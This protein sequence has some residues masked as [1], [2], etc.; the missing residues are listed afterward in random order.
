MQRCAGAWPHT[1]RRYDGCMAMSEWWTYR[2]S[3]FLLFSART[4]HR[5]FELYNADVWPAH[6]LVIGL[7]LALCAAL[8]QERAWAPRA[9]CALLAVAWLWVAW[10][11]HWQRFASINWAASWFA[12]AFAIEGVL[13][14]GWAVF[15]ANAQ[16]AGRPGGRAR[17]VGLFLWLF[18]LAVQPVIG[19]L[20][21]RPWQQ[22]EVLGLAPDPTVLGTLGV[23]LLVR[24]GN[25]TGAA[26]P[27][28]LAIAWWLLCPIPLL[29]CAI[30]GMTLATMASAEALL[31]P[32][33]ALLAT[34]VAARGN[35]P[36]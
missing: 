23:L 19:T 21:G 9:T 17:K 29:W 28:R 22:A 5:L 36:H 14:L 3:D 34:A 20:L 35:Q 26:A 15:D 33:A 7:G 27:R 12:A 25:R 6:L 4:Y 2:P 10:A 30:T 16:V 31:L 18:A 13:L 11:F 1:L 32:G 8:W 24:P